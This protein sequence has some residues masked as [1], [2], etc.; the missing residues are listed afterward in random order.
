MPVLYRGGWLG[1]VGDHNSGRLN[2]SQEVTL[3][4]GSICAADAKSM[5]NINRVAIYSQ[6]AFH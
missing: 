2:T 4:N 3:P 5:D 6:V 1:V